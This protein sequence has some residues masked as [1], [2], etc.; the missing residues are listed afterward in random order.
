MHTFHPGYY[1][2]GL[3]T[4]VGD[5]Y[6]DV[7]KSVTVTDPDNNGY[8]PF[9]ES[10]ITKFVV[11]PNPNDGRFSVEVGLT[12]VCPIRLRIVNIGS[13]L[14]LGDYRYNGEKAYVLP[15]NLPLAIG[16]Y[17]ILLET[18]TGYMNIKMVVK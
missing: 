14:T 12:R 17:A 7:L 16:V 2:V 3:R 15:Y 13:G 5:C 4:Y 6:Q 10:V 11:Y 9:G 18:P 8:D 1:S